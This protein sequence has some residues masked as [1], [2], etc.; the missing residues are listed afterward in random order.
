MRSR[1]NKRLQFNRVLHKCKDMNTATPEYFI[2][3]AT[4]HGKYT[5]GTPSGRMHVQLNGSEMCSVYL[6][7]KDQMG[8]FAW[9][10]DAII[11]VKK[12]PE[13][14]RGKEIYEAWMLANKGQESRNDR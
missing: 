2:D 10:H 14:D 12:V 8:F 5:F 13:K 11:E 3:E 1:A 6:L 7:K 4:G 9:I